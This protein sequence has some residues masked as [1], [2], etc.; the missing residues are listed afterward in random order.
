MYA[1]IDQIASTLLKKTS[2]N[3]QEK[4]SQFPRNSSPHE[5]NLSYHKKCFLY[6]KLKYY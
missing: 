6:R 1:K 3:P 5:E 4:I 2:I